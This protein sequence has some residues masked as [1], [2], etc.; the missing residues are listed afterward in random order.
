MISTASCSH[1]APDVE[2]SSPL[3]AERVPGSGGL[4]AGRGGAARVLGAGIW[5]RIPI[6]HFDARVRADRG[7]RL[8]DPLSQP[9]RP[10]GGGIAV[11][12]RRRTGDARVRWPTGQ[13]PADRRRPAGCPP[14]PSS[15]VS[16]IASRASGHGALVR[17]DVREVAVDDHRGGE[18]EEPADADRK[19]Q[20]VHERQV[21]AGAQEPPG[22]PRARSRRRG[23]RRQSTPVPRPASLGGRS[24][25]SRIDRRAVLRRRDA[26]HHR[27]PQRRA[28]L[29]RGVVRRRARTGATGRNRRHDRRRHR[30]HREREAGG[31]GA[32]RD[33]DVQERRVDVRR[34]GA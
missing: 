27:H 18:R 5:R 31:A 29:T 32:Q 1:Y 2:V 13:P 6:L 23:P 28:E 15:A 19:V 22:R 11:L 26:P 20:T 17:D 21:G 14:R 8:H 10:A 12:E 30:R 25:V 33:E 9:P 4:R 7:R 34:R 24:A 3:A 16:S